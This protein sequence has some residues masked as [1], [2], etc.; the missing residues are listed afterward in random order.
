[1]GK[2][3]QSRGHGQLLLPER[4]LET[5]HQTLALGMLK[6]S[7][8]LSECDVEVSDAVLTLRP[9]LLASIA[10]VLEVRTQFLEALMVSRGE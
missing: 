5:L 3:R 4:K 10:L 1:M 8:S 9:V 2:V 6:S 7:T